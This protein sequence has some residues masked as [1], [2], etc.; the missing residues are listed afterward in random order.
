M[1]I[2]I[3]AIVSSS[4]FG[5]YVAVDSGKFAKMAGYFEC[6]AGVTERAG[7]LEAKLA[8]ADLIGAPSYIAPE[9]ITHD[10]SKPQDEG[11]L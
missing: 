11:Q 6:Q 9:I 1:P 7:E 2:I 10:I 4:I 3:A 8:M 5:S